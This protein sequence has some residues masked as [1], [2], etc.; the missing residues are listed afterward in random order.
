[1]A[2]LTKNFS[3]LTSLFSTQRWFGL[4]FTSLIKTFHF[5]KSNPRSKSNI[6]YCQQGKF[7]VYLLGALT[8]HERETWLE[9]CDRVRC[10]CHK[11]FG[12]VVVQFLLPFEKSLQLVLYPS[13]LIVS[14]GSLLT[15]LRS[16]PTS[17]VPHFSLFLFRLVQSLSHLLSNF[18]MSQ[19]YRLGWAYLKLGSLNQNTMTI[20]FTTLSITRENDQFSM[21]LHLPRFRRRIEFILALVV[22]PVSALHNP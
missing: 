10:R 7:C 13:L 5:S 6:I 20:I 4:Q 11:R 9:R 16:L 2:Q 3:A 8:S 19:C 12:F 21:H 22:K 15:V 17:L 1:M 14:H 18:S